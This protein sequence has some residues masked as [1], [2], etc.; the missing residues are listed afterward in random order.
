M[1]KN[2]GTIFRNVTCASLDQKVA[3]LGTRTGMGALAAQNVVGIL[4]SKLVSVEG[5]A[6]MATGCYGR[7]LLEH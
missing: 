1:V 4:C 7:R 5:P 2:R 6:F 3:G